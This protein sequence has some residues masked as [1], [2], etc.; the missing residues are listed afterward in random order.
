MLKLRPCDYTG[1]WGRKC[2]H[3]EICRRAKP[4]EWAGPKD[5]I[6]TFDNMFLSMLTI[7]QC[8]TLEGWSDILYLVS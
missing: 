6:T 7:F 1:G 8:I 4:H 2:N 5:G 3:G